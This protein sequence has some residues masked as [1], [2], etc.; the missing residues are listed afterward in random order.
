MPK[1]IRHTCYLFCSYPALPCI[2]LTALVIVETVCNRES[3]SPSSTPQRRST[4]S[5]LMSSTAVS[6]SLWGV[7]GCEGCERCEGVRVVSVWVAWAYQLKEFL[8]SFRKWQNE[9]T[10]G[11]DAS[12]EAL[13][14]TLAYSSLLAREDKNGKW[15]PWSLLKKVLNPQ[16]GVPV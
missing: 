3:T 14:L 7:W 5:T 6:R 8:L 16:M 10:T 1:S 12:V 2:W 13:K 11:A 4:T 9:S 15:S